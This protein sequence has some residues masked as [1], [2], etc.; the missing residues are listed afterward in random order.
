MSRRRTSVIYKAR[1]K[2]KNTHNAVRDVTKQETE[3]AR[4]KHSVNSFKGRLH[5]LSLSVKKKVKYDTQ[6]E[7]MN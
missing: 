7:N 3:R 1:G 4:Q 5:E 6:L 2:K